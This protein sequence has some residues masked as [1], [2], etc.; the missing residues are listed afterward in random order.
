MVI[1]VFAYQVLNTLF[2]A[3]HAVSA[4]PD[5][6]HRSYRQVTRAS[7][8]VP[9]GSAEWTDADWVVFVAEALM[10]GAYDRTTG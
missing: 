4:L 9:D 2:V 5:G 3:A 8:P 6:Q 1:Q 10:D 7:I